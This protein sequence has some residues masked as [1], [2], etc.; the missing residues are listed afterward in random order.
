VSHSRVELDLLQQLRSIGSGERLVLQ[1]AT[2]LPT[3][4]VPGI[5]KM[6]PEGDDVMDLHLSSD[7]EKLLRQKIE[8]GQ[9]RSADEV[10]RKALHALEAQ[11]QELDAQATAFKAEIERRLASGPATPMDFSAVK[12]SIREKAEAQKAGRL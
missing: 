7:L 5:M 4:S 12:R 6:Q 9:Y 11:D 3:M 8:S 2:R 1:E 10:I